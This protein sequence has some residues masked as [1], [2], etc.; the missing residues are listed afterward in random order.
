[1]K[2]FAGSDSAMASLFG[3]GTGLELDKLANLGTKARAQNEQSA[4]EADAYGRKA[5]KQAQG[6]VDQGEAEADMIRSQA[7]SQDSQGWASA[8]GGFGQQVLGGLGSMGGAGGAV[9]ASYS[10]GT[11]GGGARAASSVIPRF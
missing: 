9:P 3:G 1:M 5:A 4:M 6:I 8:I 2:R 10:G 7:S 11:F